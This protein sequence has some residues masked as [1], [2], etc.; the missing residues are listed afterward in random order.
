MTAN[1]NQKL[2]ELVQK[3]KDLGQR[4]KS[5]REGFGSPLTD[6]IFE[7]VN[8]ISAKLPSGNGNSHPQQPPQ[9]QEPKVVCPRCGK[10]F[11]EEIAFCSG[12]GFDFSAEARRQLKEG[13][14]RG[15]RVGVVF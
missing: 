3:L 7:R 12:C 8:R 1:Q 9:P 15:A 14:E 4:L 11:L 6:R 2:D 5:T 10:T 13:F